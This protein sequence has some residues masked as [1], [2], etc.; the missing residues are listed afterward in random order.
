M[1]CRP[2]FFVTSV[3][4]RSVGDD[5]GLAKN[6]SIETRTSPVND[7]T[8][9]SCDTPPQQFQIVHSPFSSPARTKPTALSESVFSNRKPFRGA[10]HFLSNGVSLS[11]SLISASYEI[12]LCHHAKQLTTIAIKCNIEQLKTSPS[13]SNQN[14]NRRKH[15]S[16]CVLF[17]AKRSEHFQL[18][19]CVLRCHSKKNEKLGVRNLAVPSKSPVSG[20]SAPCPISSPISSLIARFRSGSKDNTTNLVNLT[21]IEFEFE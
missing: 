4:D 11:G 20:E 2:H 21:S 7:Q 19:R 16:K 10:N 3:G 6:Q 12:H 15:K 14:K 5:S 18:D 1:F 17:S 9:V 8:R 13:T